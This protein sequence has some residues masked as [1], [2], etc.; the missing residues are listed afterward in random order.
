[1][2]RFKQF[3]HR[4]VFGEEENETASNNAQGSIHIVTP[5]GRVDFKAD[6]TEFDDIMRASK[7]IREEARIMFPEKFGKEVIW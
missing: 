5:N 6:F 2:N 7:L 1:M 4:F 3:V